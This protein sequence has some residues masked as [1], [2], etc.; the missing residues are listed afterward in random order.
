MWVFY[1]GIDIANVS[2]IPVTRW[3]RK[4]M[5]KV[6]HAWMGFFHPVV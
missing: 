3:L 2:P 4:A 1:C 6:F 5:E